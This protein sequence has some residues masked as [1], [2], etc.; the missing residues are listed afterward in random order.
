MLPKTG[1]DNTS[2][3]NYRPISLLNSLAKLFENILLIR[4]NFK[5]KE[6][7]LIREEQYGFKKGHSTTHALTRIERIT[8]GF[9]NN[10]ATLA[11]FLDIE[12][13]FDKVWITGLIYKLI[14]EGTP[15]HF[16]HNT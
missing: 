10:K 3:L 1:K 16:I 12:R 14:K 8:L 4:L 2:P 15:A 7:N 11:L 5:L 9:N 6:L 13:A